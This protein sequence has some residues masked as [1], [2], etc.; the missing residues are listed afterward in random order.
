VS[1]KA[2]QLQPTNPLVDILLNGKTRINY[3]SGIYVEIASSRD[4]DLGPAAKALVE[5]LRA[6]GIPAQGQIS[7]NEPDIAAIHLV[8][9]SK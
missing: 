6:E 3:V 8:I 9:G 4:S 1:T 2:G 7:P 5:A